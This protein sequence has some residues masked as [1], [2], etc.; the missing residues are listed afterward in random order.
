MYESTYKHWKLLPTRSVT[1]YTPP[2]PPAKQ[3]VIK[4][5]DLYSNRQKLS[6][7]VNLYTFQQAHLVNCNKYNISAWHEYPCT[8]TTALLQAAC[9]Y[10]ALCGGCQHIQVSLRYTRPDIANFALGS[11]KHFAQQFTLFVM[12]GILGRCRH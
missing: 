7:T 4:T 2:P 8:L 10:V 1:K 9:V 6:Y 3:H 11:L 12:F 5:F